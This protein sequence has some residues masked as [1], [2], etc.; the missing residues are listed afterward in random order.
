MACGTLL[1]RRLVEQHHLVLNWLQELVAPFAAHI[2][3]YALQRETGPPVVVEQ[4]RLPF[5][6]VV[7]VGARR[8]VVGRT[9]KLGAVCVLVALLALA[10]RTFEVDL[11]Q[12]RA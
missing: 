10:G 5:A 8:D 12:L 6:A 1:G 7:A 9:R 2:A 4:R 3:V 11:G